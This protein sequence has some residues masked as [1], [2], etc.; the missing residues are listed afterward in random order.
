MSTV[1]DI[2]EAEAF[3][4]NQRRSFAPLLQIDA[5]KGDAETCARVKAAM[6]GDPIK[7]ETVLAHPS[8]AALF[9]SGALYFRKAA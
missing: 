2:R 6:A 7:F 9:A 1:D 8:V 3:A 5:T 4:R